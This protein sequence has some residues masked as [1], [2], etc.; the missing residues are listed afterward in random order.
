MIA[1]SGKG[2]SSEAEATMFE[3]FRST[4]DSGLGLDL[5][6]CRTVMEAQGG[7]IRAE[8]SPLG[9]A[10]FRFTLPRADGDAH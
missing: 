1:D 4:R 3:L 6:I 9:G 8:R 7:R 5:S 2:L 10:A